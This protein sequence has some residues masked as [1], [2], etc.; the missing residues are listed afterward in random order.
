MEIEKIPTLYREFEEEIGKVIVGQ[1]E[2]L[3]HMT[4]GL[5][6]RAHV[7]L[8]GAPGLAKTSMV[9]AF[10]Q[11][12]NLH[13]D[14]IQFTPDLMPSDILG[15][16]ILQENRS[17]GER[18]LRFL[19]GPVFTNILLAD[20]IN[21]TPPKTQAALLQAMQEKIITVFGRTEKLDEPF[22]VL[23]TQ[24]PIE[25]EGTYPLPE[26]QLDRFL[27][28]LHLDYPDY[29][30]EMA[31]A[32]KH[33]VKLKEKINP[34]LHKDMILELQNQVLEMSVSEHIFEY[35]VKLVRST[36]PV[37]DN[38]EKLVQEYVKWGAGPRAVQFLI[39]ASKAAA[40]LA[41]RPTPIEKDVAG[42]VKTTLQH[43]LQLN[44]QAEAENVTVDS[45]LSHLLKAQS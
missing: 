16:E 30:E 3:R 6:C 34:V 32:R 7:L 13:S 45:L 44:F 42:I 10:A 18:E 25:Q 17:T 37:S 36:R 35:A 19:K 23:A 22:M 39:L 27:F 20:E 21:R 28:S 41:G 9:N 4:I 40:L 33:T 2:T 1:K 26:A 14:R 29:D 5:L 43:R 38:P 24:N 31:I 15:T 12:L 8:I 11:A